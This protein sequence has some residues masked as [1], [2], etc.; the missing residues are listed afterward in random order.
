[1]TLAEPADT[2]RVTR[3][4]VEY[5][6]AYYAL[7]VVRDHSRAAGP[8]RAVLTVIA[9]YAGDDGRARPSLST[10]A[11]DAGLSERTVKRAIEKLEH[12]DLGEL[13]VVER[14]SGRRASRYRIRLAELVDNSPADQSRGDRVSP[15]PIGS[16]VRVTPQ[17][18]Q[19][20]TRKTI[21]RPVNLGGAVADT[22]RAHAGNPNP[23]PCRNC[24]S[25]RVAAEAAREQ[26]AKLDAAQAR[27][28][29]QEQLREEALRAAARST[30]PTP[31]F[32][33]AKS[34]RR[35]RNT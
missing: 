15:L 24:Q 29:E 25:A 16:G 5:R 28:L 2:G 33:A 14:G 7:K 32:L 19:G 27:R 30:G 20:D 35:S 10:I 26:Q 23:P 31:E 6:G 12:P 34:A 13:E 22:C 11:R 9:T 1:M 8:A 3:L 18:C 4:P 21:E 17:G